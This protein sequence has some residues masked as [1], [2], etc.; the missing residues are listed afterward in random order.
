M[1][2]H[3][4][5]FVVGVTAIAAG[6]VIAVVMHNMPPSTIVM[7]TGFEGG[8]YHE[9]GKRYRAE[10]AKSGVEVRLV[11]TAG[12]VENLTLMR[13]PKSGVSVSLMQGGIADVAASADLESLG[14]TFFEPLWLFQRRDSQSSGFLALRGR[15]V[16]IGTP[17][18]G[19]RALALELL[20]RNGMDEQN[21]ELLSLSTQIASEKLLAGE[22]DFMGTLSAWESPIVQRLAAD[23]RVA[24]VSFPRADAYVARY[25]VLNKVTLPR[26]VA[27]LAKDLPP[28]DV[29]LLAPKASLVVRKDLHP[30]IQYLLLDAA[31]H[32]HSTP[33]IFQRASQFPAAEAGDLRLSGEALQF[34]KA[35]RP[36]LHNHLPFWIVEIVSKL[37]ILHPGAGLALSG[38]QVSSVGLRLADAVKNTATVRRAQISGRRDRPGRRIR[39]TH[40]GAA[41]AAR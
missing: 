28:A 4:L 10:L 37:T 14:T 34:Y 30:A 21:T 27:D 7:A 18:S 3:W 8:A 1:N 12:A 36:F 40:R 5:A 11:P 6:C 25:P 23:E 29:T 20:N 32:I 33:G 41:Q 13:N 9:F 17:G 15:K 39:T 31:S 22:I 19:T 26:G 35:G 2:R 24:L 16:S 38:L